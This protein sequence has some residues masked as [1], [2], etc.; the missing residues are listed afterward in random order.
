MELLCHFNYVYGSLSRH[1]RWLKSQPI[2]LGRF[3][4][5]SMECTRKENGWQQGFLDDDAEEG[6]S[7]AEVLQTLIESCHQ[8]APTRVDFSSVRDYLV[9]RWEDFA[10]RL[11]PSI[12]ASPFPSGNQY[13]LCCLNPASH[14]PAPNSL[15]AHPPT[16]SL[17]IP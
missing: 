4:A 9:F 14:I 6:N 5:K 17:Q 16:P 2:S 11:D 1:A 7:D 15:S 10:S 13:L 3:S 12:T 8:A